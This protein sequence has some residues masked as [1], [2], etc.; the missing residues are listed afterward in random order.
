[1]IG[2]P[3]SRSILRCDEELP[4]LLP[5]EATEVGEH[6]IYRIPAAQ[7]DSGRSIRRPS[8]HRQNALRAEDWMTMSSDPLQEL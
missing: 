2:L 4:F 7:S 1:M 6:F 3:E 5:G 8:L